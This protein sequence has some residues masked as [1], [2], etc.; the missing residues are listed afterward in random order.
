ML[1]MKESKNKETYWKTVESF[2]CELLDLDE[3]KYKEEINVY[4]DK[5]AAARDKYRKLV[6]DDMEDKKTQI[7]RR[8]NAY[9][10]IEELKKY[11]IYELDKFENAQ[12]RDY[13][14]R[15][16]KFRKY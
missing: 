3:E 11:V 12:N 6:C 2:L 7:E 8:I 16:D 13:L 5:I 14:D 15:I 4:R 1:P 10:N 9:D